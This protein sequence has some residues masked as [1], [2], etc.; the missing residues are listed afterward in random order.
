MKSKTLKVVGAVCAAQ[1]NFGSR[2]LVVA[3]NRRRSPRECAII[4]HRT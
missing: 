1:P 4:A 2:E 3:R